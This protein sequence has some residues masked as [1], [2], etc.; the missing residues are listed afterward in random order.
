MEIQKTHAGRGSWR[1]KVFDNILHGGSSL[2]G[3]FSKIY[4]DNF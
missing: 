2:E 1:N 3:Q 4:K